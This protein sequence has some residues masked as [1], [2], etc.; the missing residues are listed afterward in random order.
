MARPQNFHSLFSL[1]D[2]LQFFRS[3][4][5]VMIVFRV[6]LDPPFKTHFDILLDQVPSLSADALRG[7]LQW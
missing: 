1:L 5:L 3:F 2:L 6:H 4:S 7:D